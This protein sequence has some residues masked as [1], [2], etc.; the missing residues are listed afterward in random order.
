MPINAE[1]L[2]AAFETLAEEETPS[3][4]AAVAATLAEL[5]GAEEFGLV[6]LDI[7]TRG[8]TAAIHDMTLRTGSLRP[9]TIREFIAGR[10]AW[11]TGLPDDLL[12]RELP[13]LMLPGVGFASNA[14]RVAGLR[15]EPA[16]AA[17]C[18]YRKFRPDSV[19]AFLA[20]GIATAPSV[21]EV[22]LFHG[23]AAQYLNSAAATRP[24]RPG[25]SLA[26]RERECLAW[27]ARGKTTLEI[28]GILGLSEH[29][30]NHYL[31]NAVNKLHAANRTHAIVKAVLA[32]IVDPAD[33]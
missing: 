25:L 29:T 18:S 9:E 4:L 27:G 30:V 14:F 31:T 5:A 8:R 13:V 28:A 12:R 20:A 17:L 11:W 2:V 23:L 22:A 3:G 33:V 1:K 24:G 19:S 10:E 32:G 21:T 26:V 7:E 15:L 6:T 16:P